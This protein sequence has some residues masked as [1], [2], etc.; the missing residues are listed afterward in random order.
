MV[1]RDI[2]TDQ[3]FSYRRNLC[4]L[5]VLAASSRVSDGAATTI[6]HTITADDPPFPRNG[7]REF[8]Q[9]STRVESCEIIAND[10]VEGDALLDLTSRCHRAA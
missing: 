9:R 8:K 4:I 2:G 7:T 3:T 10:V 5:A 6:P 1:Y